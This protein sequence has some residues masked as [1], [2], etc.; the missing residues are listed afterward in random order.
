[1]L[2]MTKPKIIFCAVEMIKL[3][4]IVVNKLKLKTLLYAFDSTTETNVNI[5]TELLQ[6]TGMEDLFV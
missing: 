2:D 6:P 3:I 1:M 4:R 5:V